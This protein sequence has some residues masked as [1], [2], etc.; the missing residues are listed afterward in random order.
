MQSNIGVPLESPVERQPNMYT[1]YF[2]ISY[3][4]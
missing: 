3:V 4:L 1:Y 2:Y